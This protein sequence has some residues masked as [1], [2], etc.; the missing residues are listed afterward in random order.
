MA[1][2]VNPG[3]DRSDGGMAVARS[4]HSGSKMVLLSSYSPTTTHMDTRYNGVHVYDCQ[5]LLELGNH[6]TANTHDK[7]RKSLCNLGLLRRPGPEFSASP[8]AGGRERSQQKSYCSLLVEFVTVRC[9]PFY[10][11]REFTTVFIVGVY[12][13]PSANAEEALCK[14]FGAIIPTCLKTTTIIPMPKKSPVS[15]LNDYCPVAL[16]A[17]IMKCFT[18]LV[19]R[20]I[21]DLLPPSLD[22]MQFVYR[23]NRSTDDAISLSI[24]PS[25][26]WKIRRPM[27]ECCSSTSVQHST[28]SSLST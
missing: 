3:L 12:I 24:C 23:P 8:D 18:R 13:P 7:L 1:V 6:A 10:L 27:Y 11:P 4:G 9:R 5:T 22:P 15:C 17:I 14:L 20:Q 2:V 28:Q 25:H 21:K 26:T 19:M 16:T